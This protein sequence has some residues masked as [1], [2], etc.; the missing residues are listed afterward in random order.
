M[1]RETKIGLL[2]G[3]AFIIVIGILLSD[4]LTSSNEPPPA[5]LAQTGNNVRQ[6]ISTPGGAQPPITTV[7]A[8]QQV[9]PD[10]AIPTPRELQQTPASAVVQVGGPASSSA[11]PSSPQP[12]PPVTVTSTTPPLAPAQPRDEQVVGA[13][14]PD[15]ELARVAQQYGEPVV[16]VSNSQQQPQP[17]VQ[18]PG[19]VREYVAQSGDTVSRMAA[20]F[21][22]ANTKANRDAIIRLNPSLQSDPDKV[23]VGRTYRIPAKADVPP[24]A[25]TPVSTKASA[26]G[27]YWYTVKENDSLWKIAMEQLGRDGELVAAIRELNRDIIRNGDVI[28]P[29]MRLRLPGKPIVQ[30]N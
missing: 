18:S 22:G 25:P 13:D 21:L 29:G 5:T 9:Q 1:T 8:P 6:T 16:P 4:H 19:G 11:V 14:R 2:V 12:Q 24:P 15:N 3:L 30:A 17:T 7:V 28:H 26:A 10:R 20:K 27:E 23:I